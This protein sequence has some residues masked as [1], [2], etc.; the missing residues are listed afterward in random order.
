MT[1]EHMRYRPGEV[2]NMIEVLRAHFRNMV[3]RGFIGVAVPR[4]FR[5]AK[6]VPAKQAAETREEVLRDITSA[7]HQAVLQG[8]DRLARWTIELDCDAWDHGDGS[9]TVA[10]FAKGMVGTPQ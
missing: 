1:D 5:V 9:V 4:E 3:Y 10:A 8:E 2:Q 6:T 7:V